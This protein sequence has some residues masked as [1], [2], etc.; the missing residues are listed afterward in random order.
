MK[1]YSVQG[2]SPKVTKYTIGISD[3]KNLIDQQR[4]TIVIQPGHHIM[5]K[6]IP[7]LVKTTKTF[8]ELPQDERKCKLPSE[9]Q[10]LLY[11]REYT[12][13]RC[14]TE[15]AL[16]KA[17]SI[18]QCI[19]WYYPSE[20]TNMPMCEMFGGHCFESIM[21][22][23]DHYK[24][25]KAKCLPD[26]YETE[27]VVFW[28]YDTIDLVTTCKPGSFLY[29]HFENN[30][31]KHFTFHSYK[32]LIEGAEINDIR[33]SYINGSLCQNYVKDYVA[34]VS[35][36][37]P[38]TKIIAT[39]KAQYLFIKLNHKMMICS[40]LALNAFKGFTTTHNKRKF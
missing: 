13:A 20:Y 16:Q 19:P 30:F 24:K 27:Y 17:L 15:C 18:C 26:C 38:T 12:K 25:C 36:E 28:N 6:T 39:H 37:S 8:N 32:M 4:N 2:I 29:H 35:V 9:T 14:E 1:P 23:E 22:D 33:S 31:N 10:G 34:F 5:V 3:K 11:L 21:S 7:K 40:N